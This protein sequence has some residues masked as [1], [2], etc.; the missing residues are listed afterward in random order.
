MTSAR[1]TRAYNTQTNRLLT[2][3]EMNEEKHVGYKKQYDSECNK[4]YGQQTQKKNTSCK[5]AKKN[6]LTDIRISGKARLKSQKQ[7]YNRPK[8]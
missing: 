5:T 3:A 8:A 4:G 6:G 1:E 2:K 7:V